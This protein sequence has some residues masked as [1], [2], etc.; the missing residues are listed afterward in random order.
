MGLMRREWARSALL[1]VTV[2][3]AGATVAALGERLLPEDLQ[4][5]G[6]IVVVLLTVTFG[7]GLWTWVR[8]TPTPR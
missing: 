4:D 2:G 3:L 5:M 1:L 6:V 7:T 8:R